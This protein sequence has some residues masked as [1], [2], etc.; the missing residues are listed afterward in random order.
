SL[1]G[2]VTNTID[3]ADSSVTNW[4]V[5]QGLR[6]AV[7]DAGG[8]V[9]SIA[10]DIED[11]PT[12][13]ADRNGV[14]VTTTLDDLGRPVAR[15]YADG[16]VEHFGYSA[17]LLMAY[18]NQIGASNFW[19]YNAAGWKIF[20]TNANNELIQYAHDSSG[21][22]T[23]LID[24]KAQSTKWA[25]DQ[26]GRATNKLDHAS[27]EIFRYAYDSDNRLISRWSK[28]KGTTYYTNDA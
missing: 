16:G 14:T 15:T 21:N 1:L 10:F 3:S 26:Y 2:Q 19:A 18:T 17:G 12:T 7:L 11:R 24:G 4:F 20:E 6:Y 27:V 9:Q 8:T 13:I 28:A 22:L 25:Y 23:N 5:N